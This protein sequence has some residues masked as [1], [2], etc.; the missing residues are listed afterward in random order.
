MK[1]FRFVVS[2]GHGKDEVR[3]GISVWSKHLN[4]A[5]RKAYQMYNFDDIKK[6][7]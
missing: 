2:I 1:E 3:F 7:L 6:I 5:V 4:G